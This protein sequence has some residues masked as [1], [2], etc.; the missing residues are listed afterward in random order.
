MGS[1]AVLG[2]C[3]SGCC[4]SGTRHHRHGPR[5]HG[6]DGEVKVSFYLHPI[7]CRGNVKNLGVNNCSIHF[8]YLASHTCSSFPHISCSNE[9]TPHRTIARFDD[10]WMSLNRTKQLTCCYFLRRRYKS[11]GDSE[12]KRLEYDEDRL[13]GIMLY[14]M[15]A[16][17][18]MMNMNKNEVRRKSRRLLGKCHIGMSCSHDINQLLDQV[19]SLV[20]RTT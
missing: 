12:K 17:M 9:P 16:F 8:V 4:R 18:V 20:S 7:K 3:F 5:T 10:I 14:N 11:L 13:L 6:D 2:R 19:E 15:V 1:G